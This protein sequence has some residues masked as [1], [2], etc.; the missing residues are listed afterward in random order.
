[1]SEFTKAAQEAVTVSNASPLAAADVLIR[2]S[3]AYSLLAIAKCMESVKTRDDGWIAREEARR[4]HDSE[5]ND[6]IGADQHQMATEYSL[7]HLL[8]MQEYQRLMQQAVA[9][10]EDVAD[11]A[12][13]LRGVAR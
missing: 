10:P 8:R 6:L 7:E 9:K 4:I 1:V 13:E 12:S 5:R 11:C 3:I 2:Q